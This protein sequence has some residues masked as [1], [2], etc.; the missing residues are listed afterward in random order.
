M[1]R[2]VPDQDVRQAFDFLDSDDLALLQ[3]ELA[4]VR[5][6]AGEALFRIGEDS[7]LIYVLVAGR[8]AVRKQTGFADKMQVVAL[9]DPGAPVGEGA[10]FAGQVHEATVAAIEDSRLV[11]FPGKKLDAFRDRYPALAWKIINRLLFI[12]HLRLRKGSERLAR[13][14]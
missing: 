14:L 9:L 10:I 7:T 1:Q 4:E 2:P 12:S 8:L 6:A 3:P 5:L 13:V 11:S